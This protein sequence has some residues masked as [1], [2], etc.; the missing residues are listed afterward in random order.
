MVYCWPTRIAPMPAMRRFGPSATVVGPG[1][2]GLIS[3][4]G[5]A[6]G[7]ARGAWG[8]GGAPFFATVAVLVGS[9]RNA[10]GPSCYQV[11]ADALDAH[12]KKIFM[13]HQ[14]AHIQLMPE[15]TVVVPI[16]TC[17]PG[18]ATLLLNRLHRL[19]VL[20]TEHPADDQAAEGLE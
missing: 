18:S 11:A 4:L 2:T 14:G 9:L 13:R 20:Q 17:D 1:G 7:T 19:H 8:A 12:V 3:A 5:T 6:L 10:I 15:T 16:S